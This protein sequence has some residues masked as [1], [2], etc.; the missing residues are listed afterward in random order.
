VFGQIDIDEHGLSEAFF[1]SHLIEI[2]FFLLENIFKERLKLGE[3]DF[4]EDFL[5]NMIN[6]SLAMVEFPGRMFQEWFE[7]FLNEFYRY[8]KWSL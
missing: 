8:G 3:I 4:V 2:D 1:E 6:L 7:F 5:G